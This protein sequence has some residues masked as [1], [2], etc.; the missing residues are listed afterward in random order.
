MEF[1]GE[2]GERAGVGADHS[3]ELPF[4]LHNIADEGRDGVG[5]FVDRVVRRHERLRVA[6]LDAHL[7]GD[8]I[9][10]AEIALVEIGGRTGA[11]VFVA[12][13]EEV[14]HGRSGE[15]ILWVV[16][17][18]ALDKADRHLANEVWV[19]AE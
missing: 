19:F 10:F 2:V 4:L 15:Q 3:V 14:L 6:L 9:I 18:Q 1:A 12:V 8:E 17:L 13:G 16:P 5:D 11:A 7:E